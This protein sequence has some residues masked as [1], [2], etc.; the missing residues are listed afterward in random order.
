MCDL[1]FTSVTA[2]RRRYR[3]YCNDLLLRARLPAA[4]AVIDY[5]NCDPPCLGAAPTNN[6]PFPDDL[7]GEG[8]GGEI[9]F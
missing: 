2:N 3:Q 1:P 5:T 9:P 6:L 8:G 7:G 4:A